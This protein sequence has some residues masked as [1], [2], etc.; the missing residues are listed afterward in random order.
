MNQGQNIARGAG[1]R[2]QGTE[3]RAQGTG[4]RARGTGRRGQWQVLQ[5]LQVLQVSYNEMF[6]WLWTLNAK[7][8]TL[9]PER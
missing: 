4:R 1:H 3:H 8:F 9:N 7:R 5:V 6:N 2:A